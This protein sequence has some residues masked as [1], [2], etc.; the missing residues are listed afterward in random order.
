M[1]HHPRPNHGMIDLAARVISC[2]SPELAP[3]KTAGFFP[4]AR[5]GAVALP[6]GWR[7]SQRIRARRAWTRRLF[8]Q[9]HRK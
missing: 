6:R 9:A 5:S 4:G 2:R 7:E 3:S 1:C 8:S